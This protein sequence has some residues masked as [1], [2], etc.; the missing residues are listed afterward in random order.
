MLGYQS[1]R[2]TAACSPSFVILGTSRSQHAL[3]PQWPGLASLGYRGFNLA[4]P[5]ASIHET[6]RAFEN[7]VACGSLRGAFIELDFLAF[8]THAGNAPDFQD[9]LFRRY[10]N[11]WLRTVTRDFAVVDLIRHDKGEYSYAANATLGDRVRAGRKGDGC[12]IRTSSTD[13][14]A[15]SAE[16]FADPNAPSMYSLYCRPPRANGQVFRFADGSPNT[17]DLGAILD[18]A[19]RNHVRLWFFFAPVHA[20]QLG[21]LPC[22]RPVA[23]IRRLEGDPGP[24]H[25]SAR[26]QQLAFPQ[27]PE[28]WDFSG[29]KLCDN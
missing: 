23:A 1:P 29:Y 9:E 10:R 12:C 4:F 27:V 26:A 17:A 6:R 7:A 14:G 5:G 3:D 8:G 2:S 11:D 19:S 21:S 13:M 22:S 24:L 18:V 15:A 20:R 16:P 25:V 28:V